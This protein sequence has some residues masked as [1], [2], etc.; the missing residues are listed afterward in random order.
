MRE[1][2]QSAILG[3]LGLL[4]TNAHLMDVPSA[5][6]LIKQGTFVHLVK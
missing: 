3:Q 4:C 1:H 2:H 6:L 5:G